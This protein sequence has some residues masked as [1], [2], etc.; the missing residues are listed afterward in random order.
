MS[1]IPAIMA[2]LREDSAT[3]V[4]MKDG[5]AEFPSYDH[6]VSIQLKQRQRDALRAELPPL[7]VIPG[8]KP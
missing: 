3:I 5:L 4:A 7:E 6:A 1:S 8:G 2:T